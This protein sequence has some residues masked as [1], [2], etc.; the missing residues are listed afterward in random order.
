MLIVRTAL[1]PELAAAWSEACA[2][3]PGVS[4]HIVDA[5]PSGCLDGLAAVD[6]AF[7]GQAVE[8]GD[9]DRLGIDVEVTTSG[10]S[11]IG[12]SAYPVRL[13]CTARADND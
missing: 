2:D 11:G 4:V 13:A 6:R 9:G 12:E 8:H 7:L 1:E 10:R 5:V 3:L